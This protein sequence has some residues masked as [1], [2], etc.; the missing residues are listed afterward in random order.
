MPL[1]S[2]AQGCRS[3]TASISG[4]VAAICASL[5]GCV[6]SIVDLVTSCCVGVTACL[7]PCLGRGGVATAGP[8]VV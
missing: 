4:C 6:V 3:I 5:T 7:C 8:I 2:V 1:R